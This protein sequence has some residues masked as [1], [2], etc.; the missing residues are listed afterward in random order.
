LS[1]DQQ[2]TLTTEIAALNEQLWADNASQDGTAVS[3][4][5]STDC[6]TEPGGMTLVEPS[7][8]DIATRDKLAA[9]VVLARWADR[10]GAECAANWNDTVGK[11]LGLT[12][13]AE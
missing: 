9:D 1:A 12:A 7:A 10:C 8:A 4:L 6:P 3:C 5:T 13:K 2:A 11:I